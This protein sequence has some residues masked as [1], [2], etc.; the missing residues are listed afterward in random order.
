MQTP[1][2][3]QQPALPWGATS[4]AANADVKQVCLPEPEPSEALTDPERSAKRARTGV[5][6][7]PPA[8]QNSLMEGKLPRPG[9]NIEVPD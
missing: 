4:E 1:S 2:V 8:D 5:S 9:D 7:P 6:S 3:N